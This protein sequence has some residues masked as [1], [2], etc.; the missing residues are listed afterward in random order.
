MEKKIETEDMAVRVAKKLANEVHEMIVAK[1]ITEDYADTDSNVSRIAKNLVAVSDMEKENLRILK[2]AVMTLIQKYDKL[3]IDLGYMQDMPDV[4][5]CNYQ[6]KYEDLVVFNISYD[7]NDGGYDVVGVDE[8]G[9]D[10]VGNDH[11][12]TLDE[13]VSKFADYIKELD[14]KYEGQ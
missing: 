14:A 5:Y 1:G 11:F 12:D 2:D 3:D 8:Y 7:W 10:V 13:M 4:I 9:E 6:S